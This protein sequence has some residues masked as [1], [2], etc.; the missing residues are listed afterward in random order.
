MCVGNWVYR[1]SRLMT[2][3]ETRR[4]GTTIVYLVLLPMKETRRRDTTVVRLVR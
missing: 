1:V 4:R 3:G 2:E